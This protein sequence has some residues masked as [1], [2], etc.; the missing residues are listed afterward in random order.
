MELVVGKR[1]VRKS[2]GR[3]GISVNCQNLLEGSFIRLA[4][5]AVEEN[6]F[7]DEL[8]H[9][10]VQQRKNNSQTFVDNIHVNAVYRVRYSQ[11]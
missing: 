1:L 8:V 6:R 9:V 10:L 11:S 2:I 4:I 7:H 3:Q 5:V